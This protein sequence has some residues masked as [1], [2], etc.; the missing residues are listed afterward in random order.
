M[1]KPNFFCN[2]ETMQFLAQLPYAAEHP[3]ED[4]TVHFIDAPYWFIF[5]ADDRSWTLRAKQRGEL[6][7]PDESLLIELAGITVSKQTGE[8]EG[9]ATDRAL[10]QNMAFFFQACRNLSFYVQQNGLAA[11]YGKLNPEDAGVLLTVTNGSLSHKPVRGTQ[12]PDLACFTLFGQTAMMRPYMEDFIVGNELFLM[13]LDEQIEAAENGTDA[14]MEAL[15]LTYLNGDEEVTPDPAKAVYWFQKLAERGSTTAQFNLALHH[16]KGFGTPRSFT[17]ALRWLK[18][19]AAGGDSDAEAL[20]PTLQ[21]AVDA[22]QRLAAAP[23]DAQAQ[24]DLAGIYMSLGGSLDQA[25]PQKDYETA[26]A[27]AEA[28]A[29]QGNGDGIWALALAYEHGRGVEKNINRAVVLYDYGASLGHAA[30]QHSLACYYFRGDY[31]KK[32]SKKAFELC[33]RSAEQGYGLAMADVG[34]CYQFATGVDGNMKTAVE[35]YEKSLA[36][37]PDPELARKTAVFKKMSA[38][39]KHWGEDYPC[40]EDDE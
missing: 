3:T 9:R 2:T 30:C 15:A 19:S 27:L 23:G 31:L 11:E 33:M 29:D 8:G 7:S 20:L 28:A 40:V 25:G 14:C 12:R 22:E 39:D 38:V 5:T 4:L 21:K 6:F 10:S 13:N 37:L 24:A 36:V 18:Q 26:F 34:R 16:A 1:Y 35:W 17:E 32:N